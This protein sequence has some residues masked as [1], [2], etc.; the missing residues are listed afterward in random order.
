VTLSTLVVAQLLHAYS[1]RAGDARPLWSARTRRNRALHAAVLGTIAVQA[2]LPLLP[3]GRRL[4]GVVRPS[5]LDALTAT[6]LGGAA[7]G[8]NELSKIRLGR[9][10]RETT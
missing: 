10:A 6:A 2:A 7:L 3:A 4:L 1:A 5:P 8:A 9:R